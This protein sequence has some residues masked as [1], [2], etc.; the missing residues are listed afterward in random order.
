VVVSGYID[1]EIRASLRPFGV[2]D[3]VDKPFEIKYLSDVV[4]RVISSQTLEGEQVLEDVSASSE[5]LVSDI[6]NLESSD[7]GR[8]AVEMPALEDSDLEASVLEP[9]ASEAPV[10]EPAVPQTTNLHNPGVL[11]PR[12]N[13]RR[14]RERVM[15]PPPRKPPFW[16]SL[17]RY[18]M[19]QY[20]LIA[21]VCI[22]L[23]S[24][25]MIVVERSQEVP[26]ELY[27]TR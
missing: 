12:R 22:L 15:V 26:I 18:G 6:P 20:F 2:V 17:F 14:N 9:S 27:P 25:L 3:F 19:V 13:H 10:S 21:V 4:S 1:D 16:R 8:S 23:G 11:A 5:E 7:S 24:F